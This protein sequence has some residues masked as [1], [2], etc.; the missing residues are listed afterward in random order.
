V[1]LLPW[2][3][4]YC[5]PNDLLQSKGD[6]HEITLQA[7]EITHGLIFKSLP[8]PHESKPDIVELEVKPIR[9]QVK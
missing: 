8:I 4:K 2:V 9:F 7:G 5:C 3:I 1:Q 6:D